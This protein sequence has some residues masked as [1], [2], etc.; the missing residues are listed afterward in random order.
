MKKKYQNQNIGI[1][2]LIFK[3]REVPLKIVALDSKM[4]WVGPRL[5][6]II[7]DYEFEQGL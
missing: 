1:I 4:C 5:N 6:S 7:V 2:Q 3:I